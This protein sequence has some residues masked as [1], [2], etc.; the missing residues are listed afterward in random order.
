[1]D[2]YSHVWFDGTPEKTAELLRAASEAR[3]WVYR[4]SALAPVHV[5]WLRQLEDV[6]G[7]MC[8]FCK[9]R[10]WIPHETVCDAPP[11]RAALQFATAEEARRWLCDW[12][13]TELQDEEREAFV[14]ERWAHDA[15]LLRMAEEY[16]IYVA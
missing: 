12:A 11:P 15:L 4:P 10:G 14:R 9:E 7:S 13:A 8:H 2:A 5:A 16:G 1:M 3:V 6:K